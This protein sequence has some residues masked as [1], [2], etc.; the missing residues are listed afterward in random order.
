MFV[1]Y[2][3]IKTNVNRFERELL[4]GSYVGEIALKN[5]TGWANKNISIDGISLAVHQL[6]KH[7]RLLLNGISII[8]ATV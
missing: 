3:T 6:L 8:K 7:E 2:Q 4:V 1:G 5:Y